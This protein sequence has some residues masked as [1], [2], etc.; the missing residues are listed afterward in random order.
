MNT[1]FNLIDEPWIP[2]TDPTGKVVELGIRETLA[3]A[4]R[5]IEISG[6]S[7]IVTVAL[8]RLL[9]AILHRVVE[10][11]TDMRQWSRLWADGKGR[12]ENTTL[13]EYLTKQHDNFELFDPERPF[14]QAADERVKEKSV[15]SM[16]MDAASGNNGTL[17]DHHTEAGGLSLTPAQA[18]R[19]L[20]AAQSF[21]LAG[22]SG[23][24]Q[25][26]TYAPCVGGIL[27]LVQGKTLF[28]TLLLNMVR[29]GKD[30][31]IPKLG[32]DLPTWEAADPYAERSLPNGYLDYLTWQN[33]RILLKPEV[34]L[35]GVT[36]VRNMTMAPGLRMDGEVQNPMMHYDANN[37]AERSFPLRFSES[38]ALWR[39]S[40]ALFKLR[41]EGI[42]PP[43][44]VDW[45]ATLSSNGKI[46]K[47]ETRRIS[48]LG[49][50][51][52]QAKMEFFRGERMPLR[53]E[54]LEDKTLVEALDSALK[55]AE[56]VARQLWGSARTLATFLVAPESDSPEGN[57]PQKEDLK[58]K[59]GPWGIERR[60]WARLEAPFM[61]TLETLP[62]D[63]SIALRNWQE[64]LKRT[65]WQSLDSITESLGT[66]PR[67]L[68]ATVQA[69]G[70]LAAGLTKVFP[71]ETTL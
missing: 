26:F 59:M 6:D 63:S 12:W 69:R 30:E 49:M 8:H 62:D 71:K 25:K 45:L 14:Y 3:N 34:G 48:A 13:D 19:H 32:D 39:D 37:K 70:Q 17:F 41:T 47:S 51:N 28:Q 33:R 18:A 61:V 24:D 5:L 46:E 21:G 57:K 54:Y 36:R 35:D 67:A 31:P 42:R 23:L 56:D 52:D 27:F 15:A 64:T 4:H 65:A 10:G 60:Y 68:K 43:L 1:S 9:L 20:L 53:N 44:S 40:S 38:K 22:L 55:M 58:Q 29:Y 11:P 2:C 50:V 66:S 16:V 7:P